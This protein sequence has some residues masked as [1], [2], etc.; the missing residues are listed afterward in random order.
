MAAW[1]PGADPR[2]C[3]PAPQQGF[4]VRLTYVRG[5]GLSPEI[6]GIPRH[7]PNPQG[8]FSKKLPTWVGMALTYRSWLVL[9]TKGASDLKPVSLA[10]MVDT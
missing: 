6:Q 8:V 5:A 1:V 10:G 7:W 9:R 2:Y 3:A 4:W